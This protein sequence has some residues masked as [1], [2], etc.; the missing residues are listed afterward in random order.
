MLKRFQESGA[1]SRTRP[2]HAKRLGMQLAALGT[3]M[4]VPGFKLPSLKGT[5][6][7]RWLIRVNGNRRAIFEF[8]DGHAVVLDD[9][10]GCRC[11]YPEFQPESKASG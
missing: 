10:D 2:R 5:D 7:E 8:R 6:R 11:R 9:E 4:D 3:D 1:P